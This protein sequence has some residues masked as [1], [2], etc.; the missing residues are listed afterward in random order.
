M[1]KKNSKLCASQGSTFSHF[2]SKFLIEFQISDFTFE[3][4]YSKF[5]N[6]QYRWSLK[7]WKID[8]TNWK[9][10]RRHISAR[11][12]KT[13]YRPEFDKIGIDFLL[14]IDFEFLIVELWIRKIGSSRTGRRCKIRFTR[15][16]S[17]FSEA[18]NSSQ[19]NRW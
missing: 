18:R 14:K 2:W 7:K 16:G 12:G 5:L 1:G 11:K 9:F 8:K 10:N 6:F 15:N 3:I 17:H 19:I 4:F 13:C